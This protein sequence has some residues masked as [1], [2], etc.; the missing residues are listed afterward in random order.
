MAEKQ[1]TKKN[2]RRWL[3]PTSKILF[4][5]LLFTIGQLF[6]WFHLN[7]QFVWEWW[8]DK[9]FLPIFTFVFPASLCFW[10]GMQL[11]YAEMGEIWG[12]RFLIFALSY[13]TF[14]LLTW[15]FLGESMFTAKTMTCV[16]LAFIIASIQ[17]FWR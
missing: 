16:F 4:A 8:K 3:L 15:H 12:P 2:V 5:C 9:P 14:P 6:G 17:L 11:A 7:S 10:Y 13:L 1:K